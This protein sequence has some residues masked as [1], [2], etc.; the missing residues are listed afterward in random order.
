[1]TCSLTFCYLLKFQFERFREKC[2]VLT[3]LWFGRYAIGLLILRIIWIS[4]RC[5]KW[6]SWFMVA[7]VTTY[8]FTLDQEWLLLIYIGENTNFPTH[9]KP[10]V[11]DKAKGQSKS[12]TL[13]LRKEVSIKKYIE[14]E[15]LPCKLVCSEKRH[16]GRKEGT[17]AGSHI[18][19][20]KN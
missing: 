15:P 13:A 20:L 12:R 7:F 14:E 16:S 8:I 5:L 3:Y 2:H 9:R 17:R 6:E 1:M 11:K 10:V 18:S 4:L 19:F